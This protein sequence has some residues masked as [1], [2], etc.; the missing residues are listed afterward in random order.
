MLITPKKS[1]NKLQKLALVYTL[2]LLL[3]ADNRHKVLNHVLLSWAAGPVEEF[4]TPDE[5]DD[6]SE[7][8]AAD[9][10]QVHGQVE[11]VR[12]QED[13][14]HVTQHIETP[15]NQVESY[16]DNILLPSTSIQSVAC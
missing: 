14:Q 6:G 15:G 13:P 8:R 3:P 9:D 4:L 5:V 12:H 2:D 1:K 16:G 7:A 10:A 11:V